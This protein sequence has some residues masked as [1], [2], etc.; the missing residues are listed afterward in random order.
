[1]ARMHRVENQ[2]HASKAKSRWLMNKD[3]RLSVNYKQKIIKVGDSRQC[4]ERDFGQPNEPLIE[5][6]RLVAD[7]EAKLAAAKLELAAIE[8]KGDRVT[9]LKTAV[10]A[11]EISLLGLMAQQRERDRAITDRWAFGTGSAFRSNPVSSEIRSASELSRSWTGCVATHAIHCIASRYF[12]AEQHTGCKSL[13]SSQLINVQPTI[14]SKTHFRFRFE[15]KISA[16]AV[17]SI[18]CSSPSRPHIRYRPYPGF[19]PKT[20]SSLNRSATA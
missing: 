10:Q 13:T 20:H 3:H 1:M 6:K 2:M 8:A 17:F 5:A 9:R 4:F 12:A 11:A 18:D 7:L 16:A 14:C 15:V 19:T